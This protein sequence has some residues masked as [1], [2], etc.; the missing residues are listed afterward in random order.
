MV[1]AL[2][3]GFV[4]GVIARVL[5]PGDVFRNRGGLVAANP[6][7]ALH[8]GS[9]SGSAGPIN[10]LIRSWMRTRSRT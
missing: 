2:V 4:C 3:L 9:P 7:L 8:R 6:S 1:G 10:P 5:M